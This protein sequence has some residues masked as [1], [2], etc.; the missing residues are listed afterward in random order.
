LRSC[1]N[2]KGSPQPRTTTAVSDDVVVWAATA[3]QRCGEAAL[4]ARADS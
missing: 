1:S 3:E 4:G 2:L